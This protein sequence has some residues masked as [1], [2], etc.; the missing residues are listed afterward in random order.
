MFAVPFVAR[1]ADALVRL[2]GV[3]ADGVDAAVVERLRALVHV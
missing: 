3:L 1:L 2:Q